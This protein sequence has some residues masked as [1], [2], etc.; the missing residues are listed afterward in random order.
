M[1]SSIFQVMVAVE[2]VGGRIGEDSFTDSS[3]ECSLDSASGLMFFE[4]GLLEIEKLKQEKNSD[5]WD[6]RG[7]K[8]LAAWR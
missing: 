5:Q 6:C 8:C 1:T 3:G 7:F 2:Q 4:P